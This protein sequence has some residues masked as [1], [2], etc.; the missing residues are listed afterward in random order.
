MAS[1]GI[2]AD[3]NNFFDFAALNWI[4]EMM[5]FLKQF[6]FLHKISTQNARKIESKAN[7]N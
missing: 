1:S 6:N 7:I 4:A 3:R 2:L 5:E